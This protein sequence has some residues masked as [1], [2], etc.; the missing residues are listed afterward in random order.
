[1]QI[2]D[3][4]VFITGANRG[5][6]LAYARAALAAGAKKVYAAAR[7]PKSVT[8]DGVVPAGLRDQRLLELRELQDGIT[9]AARDR[10]IG[11]VVEVLV[12]APGVARSHREAPEIDGIVQV[13]PGLPVGSFQTVK[14]LDARGP[15]LVAE[16]AGG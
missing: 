10:L 8:L 7:D 4:V 13:P 1:M 14:V 2:K 6:G 5:L 11:D 9:A 15:D 3:A 16:P 12:D